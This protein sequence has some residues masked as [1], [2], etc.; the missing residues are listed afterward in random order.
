MTLFV[1]RVLASGMG[2]ANR[3]SVGAGAASEEELLVDRLEA[4]CSECV[5]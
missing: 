3:E 5:A 2:Q 1:W 4:V